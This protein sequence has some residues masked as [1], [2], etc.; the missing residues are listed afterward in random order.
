MVQIALRQSI[1][2]QKKKKKMRY[3]AV[4]ESSDTND[5]ADSINDIEFSDCYQSELEAE[6]QDEVAQ[7]EGDDGG[8]DT[9]EDEFED[10]VAQEEGDEEG[11]GDDEEVEDVAEDQA[12][13]PKKKRRQRQKRVTLPG[14]DNDPDEAPPGSAVKKDRH[15][16]T[17]TLRK[18]VTVPFSGPRNPTDQ[19][20]P[21]STVH[22][23]T[24]CSS[25][26]CPCLH[27]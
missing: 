12:P 11:A 1:M 9:D 16:W 19:H 26:Q 13:K 2:E 14:K 18:V 15:K 4:V 22:W 25:F 21:S 6:C 5:S 10:E 8:G 24:S 23:I 7:E 3:R 27:S 17:S 20:S